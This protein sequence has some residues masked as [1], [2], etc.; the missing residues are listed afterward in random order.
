VATVLLFSIAQRGNTSPTEQYV[1]ARHALTIGS[2]V[3]ASDLT[4]AALH[5]PTGALHSRVFT[6]V[7]PL[8][9]AVVVAPIAAGEL[10]QASAVVA[11]GAAPTERQIAVP[12]DAAR[13]VGGRLQPGELVDVIATFGSGGDAFTVAVVHRARVVT[14]NSGRGT[15]GD[16]QS[17]VILLSVASADD[18]VAIAHAV[19]AGQISLVRVSGVN[20]ATGDE[21]SPYRAPRPGGVR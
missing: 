10:V 5:V 3:E 8:I 1:V 15:L 11:A 20:T 18:A 4:S 6:A 21:T 17:A 2:R 9:G 16:R 13:A 12:L 7:R 19:A 14:T